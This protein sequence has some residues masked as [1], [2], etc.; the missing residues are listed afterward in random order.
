MV[1]QTSREKKL[2]FARKIKAQ[3]NT[4]VPKIELVKKITHNIE[5]MS[6]DKLLELDNQQSLE[7]LNLQ[8]STTKNLKNKLI[9]LINE[10]PD[11]QI[12]SAYYLFKEKMY[13]SPQVTSTDD[14]FF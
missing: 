12:Q 7:T 10:L 2:N 4:E 6:Y 3:K 1:K 11:N 9:E 5:L 14:S 8:K 13:L